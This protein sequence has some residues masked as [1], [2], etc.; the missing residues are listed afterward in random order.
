[1]KQMDRMLD[2]TKWDIEKL[3][4][5]VGVVFIAGTCLGTGGRMVCSA[6]HTS[7]RSKIPIPAHLKFAPLHISHINVHMHHSHTHTSHTH[8]IHTHTHTHTR[9][10]GPWH[11]RPRPSPSQACSRS[12]SPVAPPVQQLGAAAVSS[13]WASCPQRSWAPM[14]LWECTMCAWSARQEAGPLRLP[15]AM[16]AVTTGCPGRRRPT[17]ARPAPARRVPR[18]S[19]SAAPRQHHSP[20]RMMHRTLMTSRVSCWSRW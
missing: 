15:Q 1:M 18:S 8:Q 5:K 9:R 10:R 19:G 13:S 14:P 4:R 3:E 6:C 16:P 17:A 11:P 2:Q 7:L 12:L 20:S